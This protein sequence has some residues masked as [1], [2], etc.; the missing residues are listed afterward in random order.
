MIRNVI[1]SSG[2]NFLMHVGETEGQAEPLS[3]L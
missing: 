3:L 2:N 1:K